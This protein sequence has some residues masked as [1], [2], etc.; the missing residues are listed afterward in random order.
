MSPDDAF[1]RILA[2]WY[3]AALGDARWPATSAL[4]DGACGA[5]GNALTVGE[6]TDGRDRI[7]YA[8]LLSRGAS[9]QDLAHEYFEV[10]SPHDAGMRRLMDRPE[11]RRVHLPDLRTEDERRTSPVYNEGWRREVDSGTIKRTMTMVS[12]YAQVRASDQVSP[13]GLVGFGTG[14]M[15]LVQAANDRGQPERVT[16]TDSGLLR[17]REP[18]RRRARLRAA[19]VRGRLRGHAERR[20]RPLGHRARIPPRPAP[21]AGGAGPLGV[22]G[23]SRRDAPGEHQRCRA[24]RGAQARG[25]L[26]GTVRW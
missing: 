18:S 17:A 24:G 16:R 15:T 23:Q 5:A 20:V 6:G 14:D 21:D 10:H 7:Y 4:I 2:S 8:R 13:W 11:S 3:E 25:D 26:R 9:R 12:L 19:R 22:R 1:E